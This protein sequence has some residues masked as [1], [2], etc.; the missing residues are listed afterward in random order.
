MEGGKG[1]LRAQFVAFTGSGDELMLLVGFNHTGSKK[2]AHRSKWGPSKKAN[3][4]S[5]CERRRRP[6]GEAAGASELRLLRI[7]PPYAIAA[8]WHVPQPIT[9][10]HVCPAE[11]FALLTFDG[12]A[13][14][15]LDLRR[16]RHAGKAG[17]RQWRPDRRGDNDGVVAHPHPH[18]RPAHRQRPASP[19]PH[20]RGPAHG[21]SGTES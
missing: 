17:A 18:G 10:L 16:E 7:V 12:V 1:E 21:A 6:A 15:T 8:T 9:G 20:A 13:P 2:Q 14:C 3:K 19:L 5:A 4:E 11:E